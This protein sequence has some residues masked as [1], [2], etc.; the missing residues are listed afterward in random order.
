M[1]VS[2][3]RA[4]LK[5]AAAVSLTAT[6]LGLRPRRAVAQAQKPQRKFTLDLACGAIGVEADPREAIRLAARFGF[7]SVDPSGEF[8]ARLSDAELDALLAEMKAKNLV[9]GAAGL[10]VNFRGDDSQFKAS[11]LRLPE[12]AQGLQRAGA[13]RVGTW[14]SPCHRSLTYLANFRQ[15]ARRLREVAKVLG[16]FGLRF[17]MEYVGPKTS[18]T[19][20]QY[21]FIHTLAE[22]KD[23]IAEI[24]RDNVGVVLDS[25]HWYNARETETDLLTLTNRDVV[26]CDL[27]DAPANVP[28]DQQR[29]GVRDLPC[30]TGVVDLKAFLG[31]LVQ[32][33][34]DGPVRAEPFSRSLRAMPNAEALAATVG[35][36]QKAFALVQ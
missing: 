18:W 7:E 4:F 31:A 36:M 27:N 14:L 35:A 13:G 21:P 5:T 23:L 8:L 20:A 16:D 9:W 10:S 26:A 17:G 29:D 33:G 22:T 19:A 6:G 1:T 34:Y 32:I 2:H 11:M 30:A 15:H 12:V 3:R 24:G 28:I 25:W